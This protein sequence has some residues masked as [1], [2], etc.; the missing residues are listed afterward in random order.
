MRKTYSKLKTLI[1]KS[2]FLPLSFFL[3]V[4]AQTVQ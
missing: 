2:L 3:S 1:K 4:L